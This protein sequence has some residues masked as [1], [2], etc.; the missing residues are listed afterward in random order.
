MLLTDRDPITI[1]DVAAIDPDVLEVASVESIPTEGDGSFV[2]QAVEEAANTILSYME[3][4]A[5]YYGVGAVSQQAFLY[6]AFD[7]T[8][9]PRIKLGQVVVDSATT[10][11]ASPL[12]RWIT[13]LA[14][15]NFYQ[16]ASN[17]KLDDK[18]QSKLE[19]IQKDIDRKYFPAFKSSGVPVV[20]TPIPCPG[21]KYEVNQGVWDDSN[22]SAVA[23]GSAS[24]GTYDVSI[25][26]VNGG[27]Q[28]GPSET[29][30]LDV[31]DNNLISVDISSLVPPAG[32]SGWS[33]FVGSTGKPQYFQAQVPIASTSYTL[34]G[35][36]VLSGSVVGR[37]QARQVALTIINGFFRG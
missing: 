4:F 16:I 14:L 31:A 22:V 20:Y 11:Y 19:Q 5:Y 26:W 17:R 21:A 6:Q 27:S 15:R 37:G 2:H 35:A 10:S 24:G 1:D 28:S 25:T 9:P 36:P 12:K 13:Y 18:Y 30:T 3:N 32:T 8:P 7:S 33:I 23:G 29:I 34:P